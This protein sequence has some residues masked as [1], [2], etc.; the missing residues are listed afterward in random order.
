MEV[1]R[2]DMLWVFW[3]GRTDSA[4]AIAVVGGRE[5]PVE[6]YPNP[7]TAGARGYGS[8]ELRHLKAPADVMLELPYNRAPTSEDFWGWLARHLYRS[9]LWGLG[10][11]WIY[12]GF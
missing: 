6:V 11:S 9:L 2:N 8:V 3:G 7:L 1:R 10:N 5:L 4:L 12:I